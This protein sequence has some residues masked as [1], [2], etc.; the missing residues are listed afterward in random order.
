MCLTAVMSF[1]TCKTFCLG[2]DV[3]VRVWVS[4]YIAFPG[5]RTARWTLWKGI[6]MLPCDE[7][8]LTLFHSSQFKSTNLIV[9]GIQMRMSCSLRKNRDTV[10]GSF[11]LWE[12]QQGPVIRKQVLYDIFVV[13]TMGLV[14]LW[15]SL[16]FLLLYTPT[17]EAPTCSVDIAA[18]RE[19]A[20]W[21]HA[22]GGNAMLAVGYWV[23]QSYL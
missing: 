5:E 18:D 12:Y 15:R 14:I 7:M 23:F 6:L 2:S 9:E 13:H 1:I 20:V 3:S 17:A 11:P 16:S 10:G 21:S 8:N 19:V 4:L 22:E